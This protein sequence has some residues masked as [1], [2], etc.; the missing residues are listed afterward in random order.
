MKRP[1]GNEETSMK[2]MRRLHD[3]MP[4]WIV[5]L[6][7]AGAV[8]ILAYHTASLLLLLFISGIIAYL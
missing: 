5:H 1:A 4:A 7:M 6:I 8:G 2:E 3:R